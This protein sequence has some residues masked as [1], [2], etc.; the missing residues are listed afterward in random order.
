MSLWWRH[1]I[2][3]WL[4]NG[5][6]RHARANNYEYFMLENCTQTTRLYWSKNPFELLYLVK[7]FKFESSDIFQILEYFQNFD[8][9]FINRYLTVWGF[10][11]VFP[12]VPLFK[13]MLDFSIHL[14]TI[15]HHKDFT[16]RVLPWETFISPR[17]N[18]F[19]TQRRFF[20][21]RYRSP[22]G[23]HLLRMAQPMRS[24]ENPGSTVDT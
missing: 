21:A 6:R 14:L 24:S 8:V 23:P 7:Q 22:N 13:K 11:I 16:G 17:N 3:L 18:S 1:N 12:Q 20:L 10:T 19:H 2:Y 15:C 5:A 9:C 4:H